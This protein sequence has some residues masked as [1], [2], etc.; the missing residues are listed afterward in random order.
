[1][2]S[3]FEIPGIHHQQHQH[4]HQQQ[5]DNP[6][7]LSMNPT[8]ILDQIHALPTTQQQQLPLHHHHHHFLPPHHHHYPAAS[9]SPSAYFPL[10]FK[11]GLNEIRSRNDA[12]AAGGGG[13][14]GGGDALLRGSEQYELPEAR[15]S[16][17]GMLHSPF[18]EPLPAEVSN[19]NSEIV[20][21]HELRQRETPTTC[22]DAKSRV[23]FSELEAIY[24]RLGN[25]ETTQTAPNSAAAAAAAPLPQPVTASLPSAEEEPSGTFAKKT[26]RRKKRTANPICGGDP[27]LIGPMAEFFENLV[28]QVMDHQEN[29]QKKFTEVIDRLSEERRARE[30]ARRNQELANSEREA[31]ARAHEK[32]MAKSREAMI[33]SYLEKITGQRINLP[34]SAASEIT[35]ANTSDD[36]NCGGGG[37]ED[38]IQRDRDRS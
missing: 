8:H 14:G 23:H 27:Q 10:N 38:E 32:A 20:D 3:G 26:K 36:S 16:S 34:P 12:A 19:E 15:Q 28:K 6:L 9:P 1:M 13:G 33:V 31:A 29:L 25:A 21:R 24:K 5:P 37:G 7:L 18:W 17:L 2:H 35:A 11:L 4:Q 30:D 22:L